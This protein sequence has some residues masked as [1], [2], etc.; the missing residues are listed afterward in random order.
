MAKSAAEEHLQ[1]ALFLTTV[2]ELLRRGDC[3]DA[4]ELLQKVIEQHVPR[5][6]EGHPS[7]NISPVAQKFASARKRKPSSRYANTHPAL[8]R[9]QQRKGNSKKRTIPSD[10][11]GSPI[12]SVQL[13]SSAQRRAR[14]RK[15]VVKPPPRTSSHAAAP[16]QTHAP[17]VDAAPN[18]YVLHRMLA[19]RPVGRSSPAV[20]RLNAFAPV[21]APAAPVMQEPVAVA[22]PSKPQEPEAIAAPLSPEPTAPQEAEAKA[23]SLSPEPTAPQE[24]EANA[25]PL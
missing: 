16:P 1:V 24:A 5:E 21:F 19:P 14:K 12:A 4:V 20:R 25:A 15:A 8:R 13:P 17:P 7:G 10:R 22:A 9:I 18:P 6:A 3:R 23:A 2:I 11:P